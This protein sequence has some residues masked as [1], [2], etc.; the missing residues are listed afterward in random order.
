M[1]WR[2]ADQ[3]CRHSAI[4]QYRENNLHWETERQRERGTVLISCVIL[5]YLCQSVPSVHNTTR[6]VPK[7]IRSVWP[8]HNTW[9]LEADPFRLATTQHVMSRSRSVPS[10]H[11]TTRD[12][13]R[14]SQLAQSL[15]MLADWTANTG[16][17]PKHDS[18]LGGGDS[19]ACSFI[20]WSNAICATA[21]RYRIALRLSQY[22]IADKSPGLEV[23]A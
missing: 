19:R 13:S 12:I 17:Q 6:D 8:Q 14:Q 9:C 1:C 21:V 7:P 18:W 11:N 2:N 16:W 3:L 10:G 5:Y 22:S 23:T 15:I 4:S 20:N